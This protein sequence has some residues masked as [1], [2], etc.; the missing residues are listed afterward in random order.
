MQSSLTTISSQMKS[1][2]LFYLA[3]KLIKDS[4][5]YHS[6][7]QKYINLVYLVRTT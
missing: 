5:N 4:S 2:I 7:Y 1:F 6:T 3:Y